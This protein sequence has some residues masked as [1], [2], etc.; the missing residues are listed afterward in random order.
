MEGEIVKSLEQLVALLTVMSSN[1]FAFVFT[2]LLS[3]HQ[4]A[5]GQYRNATSEMYVTFLVG[6]R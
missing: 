1:R 4:V 3:V 5:N 2:A 6:P